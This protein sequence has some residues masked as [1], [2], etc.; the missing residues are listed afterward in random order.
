MPALSG[1]WRNPFVFTFFS[2]YTL[3]QLLFGCTCI[4]DQAPT[5]LNKPIAWMDWLRKQNY[6]R[7]WIIRR[8]LFYPYKSKCLPTPFTGDAKHIPRQMPRSTLTCQTRNCPTV[9]KFEPVKHK[10]GW[11]GDYQLTNMQHSRRLKCSIGKTQSFVS[12]QEDRVLQII[13]YP[14]YKDKTTRKIR[15]MNARRQAVK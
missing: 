10:F 1:K 15:P 7:V 6:E 4:V 5:N 12:C 8:T 3:I 13:S 9:G 14:R 2:I 11:N